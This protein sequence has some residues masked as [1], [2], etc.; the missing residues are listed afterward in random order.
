MDASRSSGSPEPASRTIREGELIAAVAAALYDLPPT[1]RVLVGFSG[2]LDSLVLL[3]A[4]HAVM[5]SAPGGSEARDAE[6]PK[7]TA[8]HVHHGL[9]PNADR[10]ADH[11]RMVCDALGVPFG[12][13]RVSLAQARC[14]EVGLEAAAR[15]ARYRAFQDFSPDL[16]LLAHHADDQAETVLYNLARG[17]GLAGAAG[18]PYERDLSAECP[19]TRLRRPFLKIRR[20]ALQDYAEAHGLRWID[21]ESNACI[22]L[23]RN[24]IRHRVLPELERAR[25]GAIANLA[26]AGPRLRSGLELLDELADQDLAILATE[27]CEGGLD[28]NR[29]AALTGNRRDNALRRWLT[30]AGIS[31]SSSRRL[32]ELSRQIVRAGPEA[33]LCIEFGKLSVRGWRDRIYQVAQTSGPIEPLA[34]SAEPGRVW[35][36]GSGRFA[37]IPALGEGIQVERLQGGLELRARSG[38]ERLQPDAKRPMRTLKTC[39]EMAGIP[40]WSR[41]QLP[42]LWQGDRLLWVAGLGID[43]DAVAGAGERGLIPVWTADQLTDSQT[44]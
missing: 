14:A 42:L 6:A 32:E 12:L 41:P 21:D 24:R 1:G 33:Q 16:L 7:L 43:A 26:A 44:G 31:L 10:W 37:W 15:E 5:R 3:H 17:A 22:D 34:I 8:V 11:C 4:T 9:S 30:L 39:F 35:R 29:L 20:A 25:P 23:A 19:G 18:I 2:G 13:A 28:R 27:A 38:G 40:P 36:W